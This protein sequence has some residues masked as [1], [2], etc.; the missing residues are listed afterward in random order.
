MSLLNNLLYKCNKFLP[1][2]KLST[3]FATGDYHNWHTKIE[4]VE[5]KFI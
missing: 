5:I 3:E 2:P 4:M 1:P